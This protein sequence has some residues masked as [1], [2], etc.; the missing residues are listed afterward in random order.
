MM[1]SNVAHKIKHRDKPKDVFITPEKLAKTH[2]DMIGPKYKTSIWYDPFK[3]SGSYY[4]QYPTDNKKWSEILEDKDFFDFNEE[5]DV[6]AS[7]PPY[8]MIDKVLEK[9]VALKPMIISYLLGINN[10][11]AKRMEYMEANGYYITKLHMCKVFKW[12][13]MS[14]IVVW[15]KG[16]VPILGYDR[17][18]WR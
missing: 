12:F 14:L 13:G 7:N 9:S 3:N 6:I 17:K 1:N 18:V 8:S 10:L 15:E 5:V 16:G 2:I 4:N 11:T